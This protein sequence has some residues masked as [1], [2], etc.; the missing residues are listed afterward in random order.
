MHF[1][2][3][4]LVQLFLLAANIAMKKSIVL[5]FLLISVCASKAQQ[6][7]TLQQC[8]TYAVE[9]NLQLQQT[10]LSEKTAKI[11][12]TQAKLAYL[13]SMNGDA[14]QYYSYGHSLDF[15]NNTYDISVSSISNQF[16]FNSS[17]PIFA[18][19]TKYQQLM[20]T[21]SDWNAAKYDVAKM[22]NDIALNVAGFYLNILND[23][24]QLRIAQR[25]KL[26]TQQQKNQTEKLIAAG[27]M[28]EISINDILA[29][30]ANDESNIVTA[31]NNL[32][33]AILNLKKWLNT[34]V[35]QPIQI[36]TT[37]PANLNANDVDLN[38]NSTYATSHNMQPSIISSQWRVKSAERNVLYNRG[39]LFPTLSLLGSVRT[40]YSNLYKD[41]FNTQLNNNLG[42]TFGFDLSIPFYNGFQN[43]AALNRSKISAINAKLNLQ[44][45]EKQLQQD[46]ANAILNVKGAAAKLEATK[47]S[48]LAMQ[49]AFDANQKKYEAGVI[50]YFDFNTSKN[51]YAKALGD[52]ANAKYDYLFKIKI[53]NYYQGKP[54]Y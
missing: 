33:V 42:K 43:H 23:M 28:A 45:A 34:D 36:D 17:L 18:G 8:I 26:I 7:Y 37:A 21:N 38:F 46:I 3:I 22:E 53:L 54:L 13:P 11:N 4:D 31:Q 5:F 41:M 52:L 12:N 27:A 25:Q 40:S 24:E 19:L 35:N 48:A 15:T 2:R 9:H 16:S 49:T 39:I 10:K 32:D 47:A 20:Q 1:V 30:L 6:V 14:T 50:N 44:I 29:T 51:N